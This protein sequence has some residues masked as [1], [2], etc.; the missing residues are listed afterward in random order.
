MFVQCCM[1]NYCYIRKFVFVKNIRK[2]CWEDIA[3]ATY[4][5]DR[6]LCRVFAKASLNINQWSE[7]FEDN[8]VFSFLALNLDRSWLLLASRPEAKDIFCFLFTFLHRG[9]LFFISL[10]FLSV[11]SLHILHLIIFPSFISSDY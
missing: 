1:R 9:K 6:F 3:K 10:V 8:P 5:V 4:H 2:E 7:G 11:C